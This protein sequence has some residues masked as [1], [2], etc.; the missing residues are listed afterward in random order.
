M[1]DRLRRWLAVGVGLIVFSVTLWARIPVGAGVYYDDGVYLAL[2]R[3]LSEGTGYIYA[4]LP[5]SVPGVKYPPGYPA[6]LSAVG[7]LSGS[8]PG[9]LAFLKGLNALFMG[10]AASLT[11][12]LFARGA[13]ARLWTTAAVG[14]FTFISVPTLS[15]STALV[16]EPMF[17]ALAAGALLAA[18]RLEPGR[19]GDGQVGAWRLAGLGGLAAAVFLTRAI[20]L[21]LIAGLAVAVWLARPGLRRLAA[22]AAA[23]GLPALTWFA[24]ASSR[25]GAIPEVA[26]GQYGS[27]SMWF[28]DGLSVDAAGR[29]V[30]IVAAK[31]APAIETLQFLWIPRAPIAASIFVIL[32]LVIAAFAGAVSLWKRNPA[33]PVFL[34]AYLAIVAIW[35]YDP[36]RFFYTVMPFITLLAVHGIAEGVPRI[37]EDFPSWGLPFATVA[38]AILVVNTVQYQARGL[39]RRAWSSTQTI[40]AAAYE[41]LHDWMSDNAGPDAVIASGLDPF[42]YWETGRKSVP[43]W[44]FRSEDFGAYDRT[45]A[46]LADEFQRV[47]DTFGP[48]YVAVVLGENKQAAVVEA[49]AGLHP[50]RI[51]EVFRSEGQPHVGV[52]YRIVSPPTPR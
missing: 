5:G 28:G 36:Y 4:N 8:Y 42:T 16:S 37:R 51:E 48:A 18:E 31:V 15:F 38:M 6:V 27:Y 17:L 43:S 24:V 25:A 35:P 49:Y 1:N 46:V 30:G 47:V 12:L 7:A 2:A 21:S 45:P 9:N 14:V 50:E 40:P 23:A 26:R 33:L 32:L 20:G 10:L 52:V 41:P 19:V 34:A 44:D 13:A 11:F 3:S 39:V 29:L 22:F